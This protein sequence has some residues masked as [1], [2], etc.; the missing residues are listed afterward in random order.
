MQTT[1]SK[2]VVNKLWCLNFMKLTL[3][4]V[5]SYSTLLRTV[6][7]V[8]STSF[9]YSNN[10]EATTAL[11]VMHLHILLV[12]FLDYGGCNAPRLLVFI[13]IMKKKACWSN[14]DKSNKGPT[15]T[16]NGTIILRWQ[17]CGFKSA[18]WLGN[19][20]STSSAIQY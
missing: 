19:V 15:T 12:V 1:R 9:T 7:I 6:T 4:N 11:K 8:I 2:F 13:V 20:V 5:C 16:L 18:R 17:K 3:K 10:L 14:N